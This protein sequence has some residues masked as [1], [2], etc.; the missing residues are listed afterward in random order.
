[1]IYI[2]SDG[3]QDQF[4]GPKGK[5]YRSNRFREF[6]LSISDKDL[7]EQ[8][9]LMGVEFNSWKMNEEQIDDVCVMGVR[10]I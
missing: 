9:E 7:L 5:K 8:K 1:M 2:F 6:L 3:F 4:G 10:I